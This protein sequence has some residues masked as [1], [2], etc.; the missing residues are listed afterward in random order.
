M[1]KIKVIESTKYSKDWFKE[2]DPITMQKDVNEEEMKL[3]MVYS[4][5]TYQSIEGFG[6]AFTQASA[7]NYSKMNEILK[8][9]ILESYF[10]P[11]G[12][13]YNIGRTHIGSCDFSFGQFSYCDKEGDFSLDTFDISCDKDYLIPFIKDAYT[14]KGLDIPLMASPWSP[15]AWMKT[16]HNML[17]GGSLKEDCYE[18]WADYLVKYLLAYRNEGIHIN[19]I[20]IQNEPKAVQIWESCI[21][22]ALQEKNF[23]CHYLY[24]A[25]KKAELEDIKIVIWDHNK[26][27]IFERARTILSDPKAQ[28]AVYGIAFHWYSGDHFENLRLCKEYFPDKELIFTEGCVELTSTTTSMA[29]K[30]LESVGGDNV[31][32]QSPWEFGECYAHD[33][34]GNFNNGMSTFLDWNLLLDVQ[35]GPN[36]VA[37]YCSAPIICDYENQRLL[38]QS[39]YCFIGHFSKYIPVGSKRIAHSLYTNDLMASCFITPDNQKVVVVLNKQDKAI[40][41]MLKDV[42]QDTI[43]E[44]HCAAK[45]ILTLIYS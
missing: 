25:L 11:N 22:T 17:S 5:I 30:A 41:F 43:A 15:P 28:E 18:V 24:P 4:D 2:W 26:E 38:L 12:L 20:T 39:S 36:H 29:Q 16:N 13:N 31:V 10:S 44:V 42:V 33:M 21:Y 35:G 34:I 40:N 6:G 7:Y 8:K 19:R 37:N 3:L 1:N 27:R 23:L 32:S 45:S 14:Y 9:E